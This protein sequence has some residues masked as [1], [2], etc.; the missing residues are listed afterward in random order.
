MKIITV[1]GIYQGIVI[2]ILTLISSYQF[3]IVISL[4]NLKFTRQE[5]KR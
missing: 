4:L 3:M 5:I 2:V 1:K